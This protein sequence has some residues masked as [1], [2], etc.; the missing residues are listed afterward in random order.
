MQIKPN[1]EIPT[2]E[3][4]SE[5]S[6]AN[7]AHKDSPSSEAIQ[8]IPKDSYEFEEL[9]E[10]LPDG[11]I[12]TKLTEF[13]ETT[14]SVTLDEWEQGVQ[15]AID[16][17]QYRVE[18]P[19]EITE[20]EQVDETLLDGTV[21]TRLIKMK[22]VVDRVYGHS[23]ADEQLLSSDST[24]QQFVETNPE[25]STKENQNAYHEQRHQEKQIRNYELATDEFVTVQMKKHPPNR[26][27]NTD[28]ENHQQ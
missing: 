8:P 6:P 23:F 24:E 2:A 1:I 27:F 12:V 3:L 21:I 14:L 20:V 26:K 19:E 17:G 13:D 18:K 4:E 25:V 22:R 7:I 11:T 28:Q 10:I 15:A 5:V 16:S 9:E